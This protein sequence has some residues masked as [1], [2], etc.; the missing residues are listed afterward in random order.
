VR[1][2]A[3]FALLIGAL[4]VILMRPQVGIY[5]WYWVGLM[6]PHRLTYGFMYSFPVALSV[7]AAT[8]LGYFTTKDKAKFTWEPEVALMVMLSG[9]FTISCLGAWHPDLAWTKHQ[10]VIKIMGMTL[11]TLPLINSKDRLRVLLIVVA[12][13]VGFFALKGTVWGILRGGRYRLIGPAQSFIGDNNALALAMN[14]VAPLAFFLSQ[15]DPDKRLR[16]VFRTVFLCTLFAVVL[17]YSRGGFLGLAVVTIGLSLN[18]KRKLLYPVLLVV[19]GFIV[20]SFM[21]PAWL[22]RI[23]TIRSYEH[24]R[25]AMDRLATWGWA[26]NAALERPFF[27]GGFQAFRSNPSDFDAHSIYFGMMAEQGFVGLFLFVALMFVGIG[28]CR[29]IIRAS[30]REPRL[31]WHGGLARALIVSIVA[32]MVSGVFQNLQYFDLFYLVVACV[33]ILKREAVDELR[34]EVPAAATLATPPP[35]NPGRARGGGRLAPAPGPR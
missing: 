28:T 4:P 20:Y 19:V 7:A 21:P 13:S 31:E 16:A 29:K 14:M 17:T 30:K 5:M 22:D 9:A 6:N 12:I 33:V 27:G 24:D 23:M 18:S 8:L 1:D 25:S 26:W 3:L 2:Y 34:R 11:I 32:Y 10:Q 15:H 35:P